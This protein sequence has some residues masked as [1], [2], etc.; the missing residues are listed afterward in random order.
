VPRGSGSGESSDVRE[1]VWAGYTPGAQRVVVERDSDEWVVRCE[2]SEVRRALLEDALLLA[3]ADDVDANWGG[4]KPG[5]WVDVV[6]GSIL[7]AA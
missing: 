7:R 1:N 3:L 4:I 6:A 5:K 2:A